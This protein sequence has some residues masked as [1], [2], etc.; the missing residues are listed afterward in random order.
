MPLFLV[1]SIKNG[2]DGQWHCEKTDLR[3]V[4]SQRMLHHG[5]NCPFLWSWKRL[6]F[7]SKRELWGL[8]SQRTINGDDF[9]QRPL[10][11]S[12]LWKGEE[13]RQSFY[14]KVATTKEKRNLPFCARFQRISSSWMFQ[15][16]QHLC[17][18]RLWPEQ[19]RICLDIRIHPRPDYFCAEILSCGYFVQ[20][21]S[22]SDIQ[23][24]FCSEILVSY[25]S[26]VYW[27]KMTWSLK[28]QNRR[29]YNVLYDIVQVLRVSFWIV[30]KKGF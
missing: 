2:F 18:L 27:E 12:Q 17:L 16:K 21:Y 19:R 9:A 23:I 20:K 25:S 13:F 3:L 5:H 26:N 15:L 28:S 22:D 7:L 6:F 4:F 29:Q 10:R 30:Q 11:R 24:Q 8:F 1:M 14:T